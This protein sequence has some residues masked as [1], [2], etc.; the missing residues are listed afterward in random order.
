MNWL[1]L[2]LD[3]FL[4]YNIDNICVLIIITIFYSCTLS[5]TVNIIVLTKTSINIISVSQPV[6]CKDGTDALLVKLKI[7]LKI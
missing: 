2:I 3:Q 5:N 6:V 7:Q 4:I 1:I